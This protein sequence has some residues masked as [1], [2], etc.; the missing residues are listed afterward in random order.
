MNILFRIKRRLY[1]EWHKWTDKIYCKIVVP[2]SIMSYQ[3]CVNYILSHRASVTRFGDGELGVIYG[4]TLSF[5]EKNEKLSGKLR[6]VLE[7]DVENLLICLPD[8]FQNLERYNQVEQNFWNAHHYFN[9]RRWFKSL[10]SDKRYGNTFLSRFYSM[11]FDKALSAHR[12]ILLKQLWNNRDIIFIEGRDTKMGVGND[13][14]DN[15]KSIHR[16]ICPSKNAFVRYDEII[17]E[18]LEIPHDENNLFIL[19]LGPTA[20]VMAADLHKAGLQALDMGHMD[21][22]YEWYR[23]GVTQKVPITGK[24]SNEAVILGLADSAVVGELK[25]DTYQKQIIIDLSK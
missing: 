25:D 12:I 14:F 5:Q 17:V 9:R 1:W 16:V 6:Q 11:E 18:V 22:E 3:E 8:T 7:S 23:M 20:T 13:L 21:I 4:H 24:F 19:A 10:K 15:A 2:P